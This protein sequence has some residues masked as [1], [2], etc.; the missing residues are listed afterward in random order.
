MLFSGDGGDEV[1]TGYNRY[2][3]IY[4]LSLI[5]KLNFLKNVPFR[6]KNKNI[7]RLFIKNSRNLY[8][9]FSEQN[10]FINAKHAYRNFKLINSKD[11]DKVLNHTLN[12]DNKPILSNAM[13]HD[14]DTW[15]PNDILIRNDKIYANRGIEARVPFLDKNIIENYLMINDFKKYGLLFKSK[16]ILTKNYKDLSKLIL[17]KKW[18]LILHF[19]LG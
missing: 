4:I 6:F 17:K 9:S 2:R 3:S 15:V 11:L 10:I 5:I 8:L 13:F 12:I 1:F 16:N 14:I 7:K 19:Q 18:D